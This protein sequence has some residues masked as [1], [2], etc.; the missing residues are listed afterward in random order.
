MKVS[1]TVILNRLK[2]DL[3]VL[4]VIEEGSSSIANSASTRDYRL[5][6]S[7]SGRQKSLL[8][9]SRSHKHKMISFGINP[10]LIRVIIS[11]ISGQTLTTGGI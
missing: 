1:E 2:E 3:F 9:S 7:C 6:F 8:K 11:Y 4:N 10:N 5:T